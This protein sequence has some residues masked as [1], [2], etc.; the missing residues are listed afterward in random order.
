M[1]LSFKKF[2]RSVKKTIKNPVRAITKPIEGMI[3]DPAIKSG[4]FLKGQLT[5]QDVGN[6]LDKGVQT[7]QTYQDLSQ[8]PAGQVFGTSFGLPPGVLGAANF[9]NKKQVPVPTSGARQPQVGQT[10]PI[11]N[12][13]QNKLLIPLAIGAVIFIFIMRG[14]K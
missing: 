12:T 2:T 5:G 13:T 4:E 9:L 8:S 14:K 3:V 1:G 11:I 10:P 6:L 7:A